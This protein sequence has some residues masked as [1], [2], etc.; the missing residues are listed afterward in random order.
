MIQH[1]P[2]IV[3]S[4][5][6]IGAA[7]VATLVTVAAENVSVGGLGLAFA[8]ALTMLWVAQRRQRQ[9][10]LET[11]HLA[12]AD[13]DECRR[14]LADLKEWLAMAIEQRTPPA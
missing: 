6:A 3:V 13:R 11:I 10:L 5:G 12:K 1:S 7:W 8:S 2:D 14:E 4:G 9:M